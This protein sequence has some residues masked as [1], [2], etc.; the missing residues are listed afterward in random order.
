MDLGWLPV[1]AEPPTLTP[2][3][4]QESRPCLMFADPARLHAGLP[5]NWS[6]VWQHK[7]ALEDLQHVAPG[8][9]IHQRDIEADATRH[10]HDLTR[11]HLQATK[12]SAQEQ[13][14]CAAS[15][16]AQA[17][18]DWNNHMHSIPRPAVQSRKSEQ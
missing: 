1:I 8:S 6:Q 3:P 11:R 5:T 13:T 14:T 16:G 9:T 15:R 18:A 17:K 4:A 2:P 7:V 12:L 10:H